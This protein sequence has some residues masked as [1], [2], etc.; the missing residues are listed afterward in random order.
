[1]TAHNAWTQGY[2]TT[3]TDTID[4]KEVTITFQDVNNFLNANKITP[5]EISPKELEN[6]LI[7]TERDPKRIQS[8]NLEYPVIVAKDNG[9]FVKVID[10]QHRIMKALV[11]DIKTVKA[12]IL[13][14]SKSPKHFKIMFS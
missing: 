9:R 2:D 3:W 7:K 11:N 10:G 1:M 14:L 5:V 12:R 13:D 4:G 6:I 8:A